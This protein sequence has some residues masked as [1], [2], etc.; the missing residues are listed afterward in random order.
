MTLLHN[1]FPKTT[2]VGVDIDPV[3]LEIAKKYFH[4]DQIPGTKYVSE[5]AEVYVKAAKTKKCY[6]DLIVIDLFVGRHI[7]EFVPKKQFIQS[8]RSILN[9]D[10]ILLINYLREQE[11]KEKSVSL[12]H[13][14]SLMFPVV[15]DFS[16]ANNRFFYCR[17]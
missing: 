12:F 2:I 7:P 13:T 3:M 15:M 14:L 16:I 17:K 9:T 11:Y 5:D 10:G 6:F 1:H 4:V 8:V